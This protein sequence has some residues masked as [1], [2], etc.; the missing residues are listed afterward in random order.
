MGQVD[1][2]V[3]Q[4]LNNLDEYKRIKDNNNNLIDTMKCLKN[5]FYTNKDGG[6]TFELY[7]NLELKMKHLC[8]KMK[9]HQ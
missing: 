3:K 2:T 6:M 5:I 4:Q 7:S 1:P 8:F 9:Q